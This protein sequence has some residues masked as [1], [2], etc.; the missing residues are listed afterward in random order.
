VGASKPFFPALRGAGAGGRG[1]H[2]GEDA[3]P[4]GLR[5][6]PAKT[7][8]CADEVKKG[9]AFHSEGVCSFLRALRSRQRKKEPEAGEALL[10]GSTSN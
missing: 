6:G 7:A 9:K 4:G 8:G 1:L 3:A 2:G 5:D 10:Q